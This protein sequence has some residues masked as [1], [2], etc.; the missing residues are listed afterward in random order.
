MLVGE[1]G[2]DRRLL[3]IAEAIEEVVAPGSKLA[4]D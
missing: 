4:G 2:A 3:A 1:H